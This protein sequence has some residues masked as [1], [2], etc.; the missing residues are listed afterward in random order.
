MRNMIE[1]GVDGTDVTAATGAGA[2]RGALGLAAG[3]DDISDRARSIGGTTA[4][5]GADAGIGFD[6]AAD[7]G[8]GT[9]IVGSVRWSAFAR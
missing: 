7:G 9:A 8:G 3:A 4:R 1:G 5:G 2:I 6:G